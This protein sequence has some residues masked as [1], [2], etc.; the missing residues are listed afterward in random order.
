ML[1]SVVVVFTGSEC[2]DEHWPYYY[3]RRYFKDIKHI[4]VFMYWKPGCF[5]TMHWVSA[6]GFRKENNAS[7]ALN[8][9]KITLL[10]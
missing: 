7:C 3:L 8:S 10:C 9:Q 2:T 5:R 4:V 1:H 6:T